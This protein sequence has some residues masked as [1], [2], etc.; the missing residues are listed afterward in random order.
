MIMT[1]KGKLPVGRYNFQCTI[2]RLL[3]LN[4]KI[5]FKLVHD[6]KTVVLI[7]IMRNQ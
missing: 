3:L 4:V 7:T 2:C 6:C 5:S 1:I